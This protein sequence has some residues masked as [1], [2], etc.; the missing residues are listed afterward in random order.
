MADAAATLI[1]AFHWQRMMR[2]RHSF[3]R[4]APASGTCPAACKP[5]PIRYSSTVSLYST[6]QI[7]PIP[8]N[9][10]IAHRP[11]QLLL[12]CVVLHPARLE[13]N[14]PPEPAPAR[15]RPLAT[16]HGQ[17]LS[18]AVTS[19]ANAAAAHFDSSPH[20]KRPCWG[21]TCCDFK[22]LL[23]SSLGVC[24]RCALRRWCV[25]S[26]CCSAAIAATCCRCMAWSMGSKTLGRG[27]AKIHLLSSRAATAPSRMLRCAHGL[28][29]SGSQCGREGKQGKQCSVASHPAQGSAGM[30]GNSPDCDGPLLAT[31]PLASPCLST[32]T[33]SVLAD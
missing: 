33:G 8:F 27:R 7:I 23:C 4:A 32:Q 26:C 5:L 16:I 15:P 13:C 18:L 19:A 10:S 31:G 6:C 28:Q 1:M 25:S 22:C 9:F 20:C 12:A 11:D 3:Q 2:R 29:R 14:Q 21:R 30:P 17:G 24:S